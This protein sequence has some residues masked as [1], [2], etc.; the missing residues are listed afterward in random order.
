MRTPHPRRDCSA[1]GPGNIAHWLWGVGS[2]TITILTKSEIGGKVYEMATIPLRQRALP[3][4]VMAA[5]ATLLVSGL[6]GIGG[7][8]GADDQV[9]GA[10]GAGDTVST[11]LPDA[12]SSTTEAPPITHET[13][14]P[15]T[16]D[17]NEGTITGEIPDSGQATTTTST[18]TTTEAPS[19]TTST[20][21]APATSTTT[22]VGAAHTTG[23]ATV[24]CTAL[25]LV[26]K[27]VNSGESTGT[28]AVTWSVD[29][30]VVLAPVTFE[31]VVLAGEA[32]TF[33][34]PVL[35]GQ[36]G[37]VDVRDG[38][39]EIVIGGKRIVVTCEAP[40]TAAPTVAPTTTVKLSS[41]STSTGLATTGTASGELA[42]VGLGL[43]AAGAAT[44]RYRTRRA[45]R[46]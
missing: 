4:A 8:S 33:T 7:I 2:V 31:A 1:A 6:I 25:D 35:P 30:P 15:T 24:D 45:D 38:D 9:S 36:S 46:V 14:P 18:T 44:L 10:T 26:L 40:T 37:T 16:V 5:G 28:Y 11:T 32:R 43:F 29:L 27:L 3:A 13:L 12:T 21:E 39:H 34:V 17:P 19:T 22:V 42:L 23:D 20:T 41:A